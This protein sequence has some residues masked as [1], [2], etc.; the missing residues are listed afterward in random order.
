MS[1][2]KITPF[3]IKKGALIRVERTDH[4]RNH[5]VE[6]FAEHDRDTWGYLHASTFYELEP[7]PAPPKPVLADGW[8][9]MEILPL[10]G[11]YS[12]YHV[13][14]GMISTEIQDNIPMS[15]IGDKVMRPLVTAHAVAEGVRQA[16]RENKITGGW[17]VGEIIKTVAEYI[18]QE[19]GNT[20]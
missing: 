6:Y 11:G 15:M 9:E 2:R 12:P 19:F 14:D 20:K 17:P 1:K 13:Y 4:T 5:A 7:A 10:S 18:E 3:E 8:Y 16:H